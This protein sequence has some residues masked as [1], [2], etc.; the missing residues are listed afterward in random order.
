MIR[1]IFKKSPI[2]AWVIKQIDAETLHLCGQGILESTDKPKHVKEALEIE[3]YEGAVRMGDTGIVLNTR[4]IAAVVPLHR[5]RLVDAGRVAEWRGRSWEVSQV[6]QRCW[7]YDGH[8][9]TQENPLSTSP[10]LVSSEDVSN[11]R[12]YIS[13]DGVPPGEL[14]FRPANALEDPLQDTQAAIKEVRERREKSGKGWR[15]DGSWGP[16]DKPSE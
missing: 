5:L 9:V 1:N 11:I 10:A 6:P 7:D 15:E 16:L 2:K 13:R 4:R 12:K 3:Q 14:T 8:L